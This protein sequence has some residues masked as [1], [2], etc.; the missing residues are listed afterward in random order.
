MNIAL[1]SI[2]IFILLFPTVLFVY[3]IRALNTNDY[4]NTQSPINF[5]EIAF[6]TAGVSLFVHCI[7]II[8]V[9]IMLFGLNKLFTSLCL[10]KCLCS[11]DFAFIIEVLAG[12][13]SSAHYSNNQFFTLFINFSVYIIMLS[14]IMWQLAVKIY[15]NLK[16]NFSLYISILKPYNRWWYLFSG[17]SH[18]YK[19]GKLILDGYEEIV[20]S[21]GLAFIDAWVDAKSGRIQYSGYVQDFICRNGNFE[22]IYITD[23]EKKLINAGDAQNGDSVVSTKKDLII[24]EYANVIDLDITFI[25]I[26]ELDLAPTA[27][28]ISA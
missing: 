22:R 8:M 9:K 10:T 6:G 20:R 19:T 27:N 24:V 16:S 26:P 3:I 15:T 14:L 13:G 7:G 23:A 11:I 5:I 28:N 18:D 25:S 12:K 4:N 21:K 1:S 2:F 17:Y